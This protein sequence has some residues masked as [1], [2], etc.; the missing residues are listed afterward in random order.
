MPVLAEMVRTVFDEPFLF[1]AVATKARRY[2]VDY[3]DAKSRTA[4]LLTAL[5]AVNA[6][7]LSH[8]RQRRTPPRH[9][10]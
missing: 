7:M 2:V 8:H 6:G 1:A 5:E 4:E 3:H 9:A 10:A